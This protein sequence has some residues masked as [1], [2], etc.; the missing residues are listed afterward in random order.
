MKLKNFLDP[1]IFRV[2]LGG[3]LMEIRHR[4][5]SLSNKI[6]LEA[7][8]ALLIRKGYITAEELASEIDILRKERIRP[9]EDLKK[10][11]ERD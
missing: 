7:L 6:S 8:A 4:E 2:K 9:E 11:T 3:R 5:L 10:E 1:V